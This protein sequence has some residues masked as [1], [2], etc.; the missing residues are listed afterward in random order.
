M[1]SD[2]FGHIPGSDEIPSK[3]TKERAGYLPPPEG[4]FKCANCIFFVRGKGE[5]HGGIG[6][7]KLVMGAIDPMG[8][9]NEFKGP[10]ERYLREEAEEH[11]EDASGE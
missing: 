10:N 2:P 4:G 5:G 1:T 8:C 3:M 9:C 11:E 7:C 6:G